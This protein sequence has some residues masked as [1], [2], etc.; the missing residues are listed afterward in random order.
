M[1]IRRK[2]FIFI[3]LLVLLMSS[4]S[5]FLFESSKNV[6]ESYNLMMNRILLY[7]DVSNEVELSM[8]SLNFYIMQMDTDSLPGVV[9]HLDEV[10]R[11]RQELD[12]LETTGS[13]DLPLVNYRNIIDT[14]L[15]QVEGMI[16]QIEYQDYNTIAGEYIEA[17]Q[18]ERFIREEAQ[19]LVDIEL[20]QYKPIYQEM[21]DTTE[22]LNRYGI[23]MV[24][25]A[26]ALSIMLA[27]WLSSSIIEPIRRLVSTA[28]QISKG[29]MDT[30]A[31]ESDKNDEISILNRAFNGMLDNI[32]RLLADNIQSLEKDRLVKELELKALQ[33]QIN[34]HFLF[35]TLNSISRL[36]YIEG[37]L[38]TSDL[39]VSVSR[40]LRYNLQ[41]LN[42]AVPLREEVEHVT[43]YIKIQKARFRD[44]ITFVMDIDERALAGL[45]PCLTLQPILENA[46]VH[47]I[48]QMEEGAMLKLSIEYRGDAVQIEIKD[49]GVGMSRE[50]AEMLLKSIREDAPRIGG[51]KRK[52]T[53]LGTHNVFKRLHLFFD[54]KQQIE[55]ESA[56]GAG[57]AVLFR[58]PF[59][60]TAP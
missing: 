34:P 17:E 58:L 33:S 31:P 13:S 30:K 11:L 24:I 1:T 28:K 6:Q 23:L 49:N 14:F 12:G 35:N 45:I 10:R 15:E 5:F 59:M 37:A 42:Q 21:M 3:P 48:E 47:G 51:S 53:G 25:N 16:D 46:F 57:T 40:L 41:K 27:M 9:Q 44:R 32:Q 4:V 36:A 43:E 54:G 38:K 39:T 19:E 22:K 55:I 2:L 26:A 18:T 8:Q 20:E 52:S 56:E 50:T 60:T 29:R 7:K